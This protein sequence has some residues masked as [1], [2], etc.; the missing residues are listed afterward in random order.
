MNN[1]KFNYEILDLGDLK[2]L[3]L[4][5][6]DFAAIDIDMGDLDELIE[7]LKEIKKRRKNESKRVYR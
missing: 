6:G 3:S 5:Y 1:R 2:I 4:Y 7:L